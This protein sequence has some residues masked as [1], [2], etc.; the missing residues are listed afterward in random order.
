MKKSLKLLTMML[1]IATLGLSASCS[2]E[3]EQ[4]DPA[5]QFYG[6][7]ETKSVTFDFSL[8]VVGYELGTDVQIPNWKTQTTVPQ[9][10]V[11][12]EDGSF[13]LKI[14]S[15]T[16]NGDW[17]YEELNG[18]YSIYEGQFYLNF[19]KPFAVDNW[20]TQYSFSPYLLSHGE[21]I[22]R[23]NGSVDVDAGVF[24]EYEERTSPR[25]TIVMERL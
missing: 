6:R 19:S 5:E 14:K 1:C 9:Y 11:F 18:G 23:L 22:I 16:I 20:V 21:N 2:K 15:T 12:N 3:E 4:Q 17:T 7:W 13:I 10:I 25:A 8:E 24:P